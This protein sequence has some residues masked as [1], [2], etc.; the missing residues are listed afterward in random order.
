MEKKETNNTRKTIWDYAYE[1]DNDKNFNPVSYKIVLSLNDKFETELEYNSHIGWVYSDIDRAVDL[2]YDYENKVC[3]FTKYVCTKFNIP[4]PE[5]ANDYLDN[6][7]KFKEYMLFLNI[8]DGYGLKNDLSAFLQ[9]FLISFY[10]VDD[11][12]IQIL[13][14]YNFRIEYA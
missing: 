4:V 10:D 1:A 7:G 2:P 13:K 14:K 3:D 12:T 5:D 11:E 6:P 8:M 9:F